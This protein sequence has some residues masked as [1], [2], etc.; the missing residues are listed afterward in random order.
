M[1]QPE[2]SPA[3]S[4]A[5]RLL[6]ARLFTAATDDRSVRTR[7]RHRYAG[8]HDV[9]DALWWR[10][11]PLS[12]APSGRPD[13]ALA[14]AALRRATYARPTAE[15]VPY[16]DDA[17]ATTMISPAELALREAMA[18]LTADTAALDRVLALDH[19]G[20]GPDPLVPALSSAAL[21]PLALSPPPMS[22]P[23]LS[24]PMSPPPDASARPPARRRAVLTIVGVVLVAAAA[25]AFGRLA[26]RPVPAASP[27][28]SSSRY[29]GGAQRGSAT[30]A[31]LESAQQPQDI[32]P[33]ALGTDTISSSV[34]LI[35]DGYGPGVV[36]FGALGHRDTVC[37]VVIVAE[38][39]SSQTCSAADRFIDDGLRLRVTTG[40]RVINDSG[41]LVPSYYE[42][43]WTGD[44]SVSATS[45][46][47]PYPALPS[48]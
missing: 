30:L 15:P 22:S 8:R 39:Q 16:T 45:N 28:P 35:F 11:H 7:L 4:D 19:D 6:A 47:L 2:V 18:S 44:G 12:T 36:V 31:L 10:A 27:N 21:S 9:L 38:E 13:P 29:D 1:S 42:F 37:M 14:L 23:A 43:R 41:Y 5:D 33:F 26:E 46:A 48:K 34:H 3:R 24:P 25:F 32:P 20:L 40:G 17:G